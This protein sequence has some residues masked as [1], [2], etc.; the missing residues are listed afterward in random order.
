MQ[1]MAAKHGKYGKRVKD[2]CGRQKRGKEIYYEVYYCETVVVKQ[3]KISVESVSDEK[4]KK[5]NVAANMKNTSSEGDS[6]T[7]KFSKKRVNVNN[8]KRK[9]KKNVAES[10]TKK[11]AR[12]LKP[13]NRRL[14]SSVKS[15]IKKCRVLT[16][17]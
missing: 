9:Q 17:R 10:K 8:V 3:K 13:I 6:S 12:K 14:T 11:H 16:M 2:L 4:T 7:R 1:A 15:S 5:K